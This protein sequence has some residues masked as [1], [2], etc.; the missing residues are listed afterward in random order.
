[1]VAGAG[2]WLLRFRHDG[3]IDVHQQYTLI[4]YL[5]T[6]VSPGAD[7]AMTAT[8]GGLSGSPRHRRVPHPSATQDPGSQRLNTT[9]SV[10]PHTEIVQFRVAAVM[11]HVVVARPSWPCPRACTFPMGWPLD[12]FQS[13][14]R[15]GCAF[16]PYQKM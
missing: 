15:S 8:W 13:T 5:H 6:A 7:I 4:D 11:S 9:R 1:M 16:L 2:Q 10:L 12:P 3:I 14:A